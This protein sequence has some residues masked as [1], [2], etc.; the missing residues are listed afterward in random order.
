MKKAIVSGILAASLLAASFMGTTSAATVD[1]HPDLIFGDTNVDEIIN[2]LDATVIQKLLA[3]CET[4]SVLDA[5]KDD[6]LLDIDG[7][8]AVSITDT[9]Q[10]QLYIAGYPD[11]NDRIGSAC[12]Q[13]HDKEYAYQYPLTANT[14]SDKEG[15]DSVI[16][17][18]AEPVSSIL[19]SD[20]GYY[21]VRIPIGKVT[22]E[23]CIGLNLVD[24]FGTTKS[25]PSADGIE[26]V[27]TEK[28][29]ETTGFIPALPG[30]TY[31]LTAIANANVFG[32]SLYDNSKHFLGRTQ[33][34]GNRTTYTVDRDDVR[35]I[36]ITAWNNSLFS[37]TLVNDPAQNSGDW[38]KQTSVTDG[39]IT[40]GTGEIEEDA[41]ENGC[42]ATSYIPVIAGEIIFEHTQTTGIPWMC[43]A[44]YT[45]DKHFIERN[46]YA[47]T[48]FF[49]NGRHYSSF[50][51]TVGDGVGYIR[52]SCR[53]YLDGVHNL[54]IGDQ[55]QMK[56]LFESK[57]SS[58][59]NDTRVLDAQGNLHAVNHRGYNRVAPENT[60]SAYK[61]SKKAGFQY[62]ECDVSLTAD[63]VPVLLHD[64]SIDRTSNG[65]GNIEE[66]TYDQVKDLDFGSWKSA[67]Y[68]GEKIPTFE[69]FIRLCKNIGLH[70][71]IELKPRAHYTQEDIN[72]IVRIV[73]MYGMRGKVSYISI[74]PQW[75]EYV[76]NTDNEARLGYVVAVVDKN[77]VTKCV[78]LRTGKNEVF[79]DANYIGLT[80]ECA[81]L[82]FDAQI[83]LEVWTTNTVESIL[84]LNPY[85]SG[86]TSDWL[87]I[88]EVL[89]SQYIN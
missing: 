20:E 63:R 36:R 69:E 12:Y 23:D 88:N 87:N 5:V 37:V 38:Y 72:N 49:K 41:P 15:Y 85:V 50:L 54:Y 68:A 30:K 6:S 84:N 24:L 82:S 43:I 28:Q 9:K 44:T 81:Q 22:E 11:E 51:F 40:G 89:Y 33:T 74:N 1:Y 60:L 75:L 67:A 61:L 17:Y 77:T 80:N 58:A 27:P 10:L 76:K 70:P 71:Y 3:E 53:T 57:V 13:W 4:V 46:V 52:A 31:A 62:V 18:A 73:N 32:V 64:D 56:E 83:P 47:I 26:T 42:V 35:Y 45:P 7:D 79:L 86:A 25:F 66:L 34:S 78:D 16:D 65:C 48:D 14:L 55:Q 8:N 21:D 39:F 29:E 59:V 19:L 2:V